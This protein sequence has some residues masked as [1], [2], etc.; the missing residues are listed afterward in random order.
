MARPLTFLQFAKD[1]EAVKD[2]VAST[3]PFTVTREQQLSAWKDLA[4]DDAKTWQAAYTKFLEYSPFCT[5]TFP[6][7]IEGIKDDVRFRRFV[8]CKERLKLEQIDDTFQPTNLTK[9]TEIDIRVKHGNRLYRSQIMQNVGDHS[10][11]KEHREAIVLLE[12]HGTP[13]VV[14]H[15]KKL[16]AAAPELPQTKDATAALARMNAK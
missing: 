3:K 11:M 7:I 15:L 1:K 2:L 8:A 5:L 14:A 12:H 6:E 16:A 9:G 10:P 4:S 13:E